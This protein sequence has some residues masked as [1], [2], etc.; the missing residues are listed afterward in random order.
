MR[1]KREK[2]TK[3]RVKT[4]ISPGS[5]GILTAII[6]LPLILPSPIHHTL[7]CPYLKAKIDGRPSEWLSFIPLPIR[8][9]NQVVRGSWKGEK[10]TSALLFLGWNEDA[11]LLLLKLTDDDFPRVKEGGNLWEGDSLLFEITLPTFEDKRFFF[12]FGLRGGKPLMEKI[13]ERG[14][15]FFRL[16]PK[17]VKVEIK[18][19]DNGGIYECAIPWK[20]ISP[21]GTPPPSFSA[22]IVINDL[23]RKAPLHSLSLAPKPSPLETASSLITFKLEEKKKKKRKPFPLPKTIYRAEVNLVLL[24]VSVTDRENRYIIDLKKNDFIVYDNGKPQEIA[25]FEKTSRPITVAILIDGSSSMLEAME[26]VK[27]AACSF[28]DEAIRDED[29]LFAIKFASEIKELTDITND[30]EEVKEAIRKIKA[31]GGTALYDAIYHGI[32]RLR[33]LTERKA[34]IVL[35]DGRDEAFLGG[36][37]GSIHTLEE[38]IHLARISDVVI[39]PIRLGRPDFLSERVMERLA[40]ETGGR[41]YSPRLARDLAG[42][43]SRIGEE[44]RSQYLIG[45]YPKETLGLKRWHEVKVELKKGGL[46]ARTR[47]GYLLEK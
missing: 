15:N 25:L 3:G 41:Y 31:Y 46:K 10:D 6:L 23:D 2:I 34:I 18:Q 8:G 16:K 44:L 28:I 36:G 19:K 9:T 1:R 40:D 4:T 12:I 20:E 30:K 24:T 26:E 7:P 38:V 37:P 5:L 27:K 13:E 14:R 21:E 43:Y 42:V 47:R 29:Q 22:N 39:Y 17:G 35:S 33:F 11:L 32:S 45:Y